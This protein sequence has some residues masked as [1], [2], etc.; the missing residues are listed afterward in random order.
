MRWKNYH[1]GWTSKNFDKIIGAYFRLMSKSTSKDILGEMFRISGN[2]TNIQNSWM[3]SSGMWRRVNLV[4]TDFSEESN[5]SIFRV[6]KSAIG[7]PT[8]E[9]DFRL[10]PIVHAGSS[11]EDFYTLKMEVL[12]S[13]ETSVHRRST[14][15]H[16][17]E[18]GI[19]HSYRSENLRSVASGMKI[20]SVTATLYCSVAMWMLL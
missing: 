13:F 14:W 18:V 6:E 20:L 9:V 16:I 11:L 19:L 4:W 3:P 12:L 2:L 17:P 7:E 1:T 10:K 8:W 15:R 5:A